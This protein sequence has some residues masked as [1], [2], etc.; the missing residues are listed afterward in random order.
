LL[1]QQYYGDSLISLT[2]FTTDN[3]DDAKARAILEKLGY[4]DEKP[5]CAQA[6][7][8]QISFAPGEAAIDVMNSAANGA[9]KQRILNCPLNQASTMPVQYADETERN[10]VEQYEAAAE[11]NETSWL[12]KDCAQAGCPGID[13]TGQTG[14]VYHASYG[15]SQ[16]TAATFLETINGLA[17]E[18]KKTLG[19][20]Q[21]MQSRITAALH[22]SDEVGKTSPT[23][24][25]AFVKYR[26]RYTCATGAGAW[27]NAGKATQPPQPASLTIAELTSFQA[28]TGLSRQ[29][30][31]D[32][33]CFT[34]AGSARPIGEGKNAF[35]TEAIFT[36]T[37]LKSW[38]MDIFK[39]DDKFGYISRIL[40]R[41]NLRE[42]LGTASLAAGFL[43]SE[44]PTLRSGG[45]NPSYAS[46]QHSIEEELAMRVSR[47]HN[48]GKAAAL[49]GNISVLTRTCIDAG[50]DKNTPLCDIG[51]YVK[52]FIGIT[53]GHGDWRSLRC[54]ADAKS[55]GSGSNA[56]WRGLELK[57]L[58]LPAN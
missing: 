31:I 24:P 40:I 39:S 25:G 34:P 45:V 44:T 53:N 9:N 21:D 51:G 56:K 50:P 57:P 52:K 20:T 8:P 26:D 1:M 2:E 5:S 10:R 48:G 32:M 47:R 42:V 30:F 7:L 38:M 29:A 55:A 19:V 27:D 41:S 22:R 4:A 28:N 6:V 11:L 15:R 3:F 36:D 17:N 33:V 58:S 18:E 54:A 46:K 13:I 37:T 14:I 16:F 43:N 35:M 12:G 23:K 49:S